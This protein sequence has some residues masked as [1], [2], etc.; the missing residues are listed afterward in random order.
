MTKHLATIFVLAVAMTS[1]ASS[2]VAAE[3]DGFLQQHCV[4]CHGEKKPKGDLR[5]DTLKW[6][7]TDA[8]NVETWQAIVDR[9]DD[10]EMPP[11]KAP[12]PTATA[13]AKVLLLLRTRIAAAAVDNGS[14]QVVLRRLNR[15]QYRNTIRDLLKVD[16]DVVDPTE[17]FPADDKKEG[18]DNL[19]EALQMSDFLLR[20]Y[21]TVARTVIDRATFVG[22]QPESQTYKLGDAKSRALNFKVGGNDPD[23][24][25]VVLYQNDER[26]PGDPR[27]QSFINSREGATHD[28][29]YEFIFD[30]ES[31]GRGNLGK[32]L[33]QQSRNDWQVYRAEDLHRFE[34][35]LTAPSATSQIQTRPR[36]LVAA[37]D[38]PDN[39]RQ[40]IKRRYWIPKGWR[41]EMGFGNGFGSSNTL[42]LLQILDPKF[43]REAFEKLPKKE[44]RGKYGGKLIIDLIEKRD[45]PRIVVHNV[46]ETGPH[47]DQWPPQS[48]NIVYGQPGQSKAE[49]IREFAVR[50]FRRPVTDEQIE[51]FVRLAEKS[52]E[53][54]RT[55]IEA[56][57]CSPRFLYLSERRDQLDEYAIASRLSYFLWNSPPDDALMD[58]AAKGRLRDQKIL[59]SHVDRMLADSRSDEFVE[60]FVWSWLHLQ[61]TIEMAPD[62]MK[63]YEYHRNRIGEAMTAETN[64]F[65]RHLLNENLPLSNFIDSDFAFVNADLGR[66][67]GMVGMVN[68]TAEFQRVSLKDSGRRGGLLGQA[69]VLTTSANGVDTSPVVRGIWILENLLGTPPSPP[70]PG[71]E[72]PEPDARGE[73]TVRQLY[74]KH[75]TVASCNDCHKKIDPLGFALE[76]FDAVGGW[77]TKYESGHAIDPSGQMP[78]GEKFKDVTGLKQIMASN[79]DQFSRNLT[80]KLMTY[81]TGRTM[82]V[83]DRPVLDRIVMQSKKD[84]DGFRD[85]IKL[86]V[87]SEVFLAK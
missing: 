35:Y 4:K 47:Y 32:E 44:Q 57:L 1:T 19:G 23:R 48:H 29:W 3:L 73:L 40:T 2:A 72:V 33:G 84:G 87:T 77:R 28:G 53:G 65:F 39:Q 25:Y 62:P 76:N 37:I 30:V 8:E 55:G 56:I 80:H 82:S 13:R 38:L 85:L 58:D 42:N 61:N 63:F 52:P 83:A 64:K 26:A 36:H 27:G 15:A 18:F 34:V 59:R 12:Q 51:P 49:V 5:L 14:R 6:Q 43:D 81:A 74:A 68:T 41:M 16:V 45:A 54:L 22:E 71:V 86:I 31:K 50:A 11:E 46:V 67:Y 10:E 79:L 20:Q 21:L 70:P 60:S 66:H 78:N 9:L 17:A 7:P 69:S 24:D 75:R